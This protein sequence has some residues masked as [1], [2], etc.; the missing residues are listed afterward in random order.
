MEISRNDPEKHARIYRRT[1]D[2][3]DDARSRNPHYAYADREYHDQSGLESV[4]DGI[5][6]N[7]TASFVSAVSSYVAPA[8]LWN[9]IGIYNDL[10]CTAQ[11]SLDSFRKVDDIER[12]DWVCINGYIRKH[13]DTDIEAL[14]FVNRLTQAIRVGEQLADGREVMIAW[15]GLWPTQRQQDRTP[16]T[17]RCVRVVADHRR[18]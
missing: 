18:Q 13:I 14:T 2:Q 16:H 9:C 6:A 8:S 17:A 7:I 1:E 11:S 4:V 12:M 3:I 15:Q 10:P 5:E